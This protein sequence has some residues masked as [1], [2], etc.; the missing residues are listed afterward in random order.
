MINNFKCLCTLY[1]V[2]ADELEIVKIWFRTL[3]YALSNFLYQRLIVK[4]RIVV[5][6]AYG[7]INLSNS[8]DV[9]LKLY[10][11]FINILII[12]YEMNRA[13]D[14]TKSITT[15]GIIKQASI[16]MNSS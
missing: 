16:K 7:F 10:Q 6:F 14:L 15:S 2:L 4:L 13:E 12:I 9:R 5:H 8:F 1:K 11:L 3:D